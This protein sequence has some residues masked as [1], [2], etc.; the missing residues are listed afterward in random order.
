LK[1]SAVSGGSWFRVCVD[2][3]SQTRLWWA[4]WSA[5]EVRGGVEVEYWI[6][7]MFLSH[8]RCVINTTFVLQ[9]Y[10]IFVQASNL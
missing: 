3:V 2:Y 1:T 8:G 5:L 7:G 9:Q 4:M 6:A 10:C